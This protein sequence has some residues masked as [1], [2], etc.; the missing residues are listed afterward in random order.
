MTTW[1]ELRMIIGYMPK[2]CLIEAGYNRLEKLSLED[3]R[4]QNLPKNTSIQVINLDSNKL[5]SW[6]QTCEGLEPFAA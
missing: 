5:F 4:T 1:S 2:L 6:S 3:P